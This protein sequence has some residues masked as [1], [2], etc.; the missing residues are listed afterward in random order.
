MR[1][2]TIPIHGMTCG[3]C[4]RHVREALGRLEG[5][6]LEAV[7]IGSAALSY[8]PHITDLG[9]ISAA[10]AGAGYMVAAA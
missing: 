6:E 1:H 9:T 3:G 4:V 2:I 10:V 5:V 8:D 7:I